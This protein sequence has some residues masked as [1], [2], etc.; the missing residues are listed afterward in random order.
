MTSARVEET[1]FPVEAISTLRELRSQ[2]SAMFGSIP[3]GV[4]KS[5][6]V[7]KVF[8]VDARLSWQIFRLAG[9]GDALSLAAHVPSATSMRRLLAAAKTYGIAAERLEAV[10]SAFDAFEMLVET[11]AGDRTSFDSMTRGF[12]D[13]GSS[14][15]SDLQHRKAM[16]RGHSHYYGAQTQTMVVTQIVHP[17]HDSGLMDVAHLRTR[18][19][20]RRLRPDADVVVDTVRALSPNGTG[21]AP[22]LDPLDADASAE[23]NAPVLPEFCTQPLPRLQTVRRLDGTIVT[24]LDGDAVGRRSSVD[25]VFG[26]IW[27]GVPMTRS[28]PGGKL[29]FGGQVA[30]TTPTELL[31][32]DLLVHQPTFPKLAVEFAVFAYGS[33]PELHDRVPTLKLPF[34]DPVTFLGTGPDALLTR[35]MARYPELVQSVCGQFDWSLDEMAL[36]RLR[37][38]YPM[39]DTMPTLTVEIPD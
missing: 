24:S 6:D 23:H 5:R 12:L 4:R 32:F 27:R 29:G 35:E 17:S 19:G 9:P 21:Q 28:Q 16:F 8:G 14:S 37:M 15:Q 11:H 25:T 26:Q 22:K 39:L 7:Q 20:Q 34:R 3:G 33:A 30:I 38:E 18:L 13:S 1:T 31:I 10:R 36:Y 2:I